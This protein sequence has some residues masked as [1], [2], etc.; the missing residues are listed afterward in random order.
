MYPSYVPELREE[1]ESVIN[2][3]GLSKASY[4]KMWKLDSFLKESQ[5]L[6]GLAHCRFILV[7]SIH[8][9]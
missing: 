5:R 7:T 2:E 4:G 6:H 1:I 3:E 9:C 8:I